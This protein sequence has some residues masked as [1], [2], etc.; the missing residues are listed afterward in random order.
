MGWRFINPKLKEMY[1]V[2]TMPETAE[3]VAEAYSISREGQDRFALASQRKAAAA[4]E[5]GVF[6]RE[7]VPVQIPRRKAIRWPS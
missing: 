4:I 6:A 5:A 3:N 7:I 2:D 1:G